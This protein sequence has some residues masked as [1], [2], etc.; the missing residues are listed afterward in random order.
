MFAPTAAKTVRAIV[1]PTIAATIFEVFEFNIFVCTSSNDETKRLLICNKY[2]SSFQIKLTFNNLS[3]VLRFDSNK[4][5]STILGFIFPSD[6][7]SN[8]QNKLLSKTNR[9]VRHKDEIVVRGEKVCPKY[10][11]NRPEQF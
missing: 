4:T 2:C 6:L 9:S 7:F 3:F 8:K 10:K 11:E 5:N 1:K